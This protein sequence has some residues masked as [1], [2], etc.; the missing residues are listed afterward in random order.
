MKTGSPVLVTQK[1]HSAVMIV[2]V[3]TFQQQQRRLFLL[4]E[5]AKG[6]RDISEGKTF[7]HAQ[8]KEMA[9]NWKRKT[10]K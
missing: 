6:E 5:I 4:D 7:S 3:E 10:K 2:D 8:V 9:A 1:G